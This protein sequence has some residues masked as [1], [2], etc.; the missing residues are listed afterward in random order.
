[1]QAIF[2]NIKLKNSQQRRYLE[3]ES[4]LLTKDVARTSANI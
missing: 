3:G 2:N 1:M 4:F